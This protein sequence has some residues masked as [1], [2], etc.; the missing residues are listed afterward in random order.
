MERTYEIVGDTLPQQPPQGA[1]MKG[2]R[3]VMGGQLVART[4]IGTKF[5][6]GQRQP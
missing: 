6:R 5:R 2:E 3:V 1:Q 4:P